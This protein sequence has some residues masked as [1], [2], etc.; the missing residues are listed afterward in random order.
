MKLLFVHANYINYQVKKKTKSAEDI[1]RD[2]K[3]GGMRDPLIVLA[4]A[5]KNRREI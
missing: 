5:E 4:C 2:R 1:L 3:S